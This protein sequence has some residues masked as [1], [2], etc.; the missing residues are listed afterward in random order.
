[1][2]P[3]ITSDSAYGDTM[4][5]VY[6][7]PPVVLTFSG[8]SAAC[9][10]T[11][12]VVNQDDDSPIDTD[13]FTYSQGFATDTLSFETSNP[14]YER[15]F[16]LKYVMTSTDDSSLS[17]T[18]NFSVTVRMSTCTKVWEYPSSGAPYSFSTVSYVI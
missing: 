2:L 18:F 13:L 12:G 8:Q 17:A 15:T 9:P 7:D 3:T 4:T 5:F 11:Q 16:D 14:I 10:S 6:G 1:M